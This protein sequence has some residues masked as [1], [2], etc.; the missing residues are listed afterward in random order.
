MKKQTEMPDH[1]CEFCGKIFVRETTVFK[2]ICQYKQRWLNRDL[3]SNRIAYHAFNNF[4]RKNSACNHDKTYLDFIKSPYFNAF[5]KFATYA[6]E[7][8]VINVP[9]YQ[10]WLIKQQV[11][12][13]DWATDSA[14]TRFLTEYLRVED[15]LDALHR[16]IE[17]TMTLAKTENIRPCDYLRYGNKNK[18]CYQITKG[19]I[20]PWILY[21]SKGG[22]ELLSNLD[23]TQQ[24][25]IINYINPELWAIK[26]VKDSES[27][28]QIK[29]LCD[30]AGY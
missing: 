28:K 17:T 13:D 21:H 18:I 30:V 29:E 3:P 10:D 26:F 27:V 1:S 2:H 4:Y 14:Y 7:V 15:P 24:Q 25:L 12:I 5:I 16:S 9:R 8:D 6:I 19:K 20:S 11:K 23:S 22:L